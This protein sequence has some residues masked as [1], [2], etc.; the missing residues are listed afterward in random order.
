MATTWTQ[1]DIDALRASIAS[2]GGATTL[3]FGNR[4]VTFATIKDRLALLAEMERVV[5]PSAAPAYR[6]AAHRKGV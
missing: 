2:G 5:N 3:Q 1:A 4:S 6:L